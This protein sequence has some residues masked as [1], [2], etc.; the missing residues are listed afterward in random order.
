MAI[1]PRNIEVIDEETAAFWRSMPP[2]Q[3]LRCGNAVRA[4]TIS[5]MHGSERALHPDWSD[6]QIDRTVRRNMLMSVDW[7]S[8]EQRDK[9]LRALDLLEP[10]SA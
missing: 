10:D 1:D 9:T 5:M 3:R 8:D 4:I 7:P 2:E 6:Q